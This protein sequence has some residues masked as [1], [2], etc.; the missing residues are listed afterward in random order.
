MI[1]RNSRNIFVFGVTAL[2]VT[3]VF[4]GGAL[5]ADPDPKSLLSKMSAEIA[6]LDSYEISGDAY[7]DARL[8]AG[9]IIE[10]PSQ[11]RL[12]LR[13]P[14]TLRLTNRDTENTKEIFFNDGI[15]T[16]YSQLENFYAQTEIPKDIESAV[17]FAMDEIGIDAPLLDFVS[18]NVSENLL[19]AAGEVRYL[20]TSLIRE[21]VHHHIGLR[22]PEVDMQIW[23]SADGPPLPGKVVMTSKWEGGSPRFVAF[24]NWDTSPSIPT[25]SV[26]FEPPKGAIEIEFLLDSQD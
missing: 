4:S 8:A 15:L 14:G 3:A 2:I 12:R 16:V 26:R 18:S 19:Q 5:A 13:K 17:T 10:N 21:K 24:L 22:G 9:Q 11:V 25:D 23:I 7:A 1:G 6:K 20:G